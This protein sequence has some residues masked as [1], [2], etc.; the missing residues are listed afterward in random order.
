MSFSW[1]ESVLDSK[2]SEFSDF[3]LGLQIYINHLL[4]AVKRDEVIYVAIRE[5]ISSTLEHTH[6]FLPLLCVVCHREALARP[7]SY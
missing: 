5:R 1:K 3:I 6:L 4:M 7:P 2:M